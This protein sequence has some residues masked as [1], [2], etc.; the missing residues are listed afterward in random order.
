MNALEARRVLEVG[1]TLADGNSELSHSQ[2]RRAGH[3]FALAGARI[4]LRVMS[5]HRLSDPRHESYERTTYLHEK[6]DHPNKANC[7]CAR[8]IML[9]AYCLQL[10]V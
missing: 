5:A 10:P 3:A 2:A 1:T 4:R 6:D 8:A 9:I 7:A